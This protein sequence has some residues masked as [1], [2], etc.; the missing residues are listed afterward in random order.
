MALPDGTMGRVPYLL[1]Y[2][3]PFARCGVPAAE[4]VQFSRDVWAMNARAFSDSGMRLEGL[5]APHR[6]ALLIAGHSP[7]AEL[8]DVCQWHAEVLGRFI[9]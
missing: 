1:P 4:V 7:T 9:D 5:E 2:V 3:D 8:T 6:S